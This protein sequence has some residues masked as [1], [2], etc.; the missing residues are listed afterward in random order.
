MNGLRGRTCPWN[1]FAIWNV[2]ILALIGF[3]T[4]ADGTMMNR[5]IGGMEVHEQ[6]LIH[7]HVT[8]A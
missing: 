4:I 2:D 1:T 8:L 6:D 5:S 7:L 3:P